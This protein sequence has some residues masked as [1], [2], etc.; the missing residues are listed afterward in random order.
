MISAFCRQF[1]QGAHVKFRQLQVSF[2]ICF[3]LC[4][5]GY[6]LHVQVAWEPARDESRVCLALPMLFHSFTFFVKYMTG[7]LIA[8]NETTVG[9]WQNPFIFIECAT[10]LTVPL[11]L[12]FSLSCRSH[13]NTPHCRGALALRGQHP[14]TELGMATKI[15]LGKKSHYLPWT[16]SSVRQLFMTKHSLLL[17]VCFQQRP[18]LFFADFAQFYSFFEGKGFLNFFFLLHAVKK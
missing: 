10:L 15:G 17:M 13:D 1:S 4:P 9:E 3:P 2:D 6:L 16:L 18:E 12:C 7:L 11:S 14:L 8:P 5:L